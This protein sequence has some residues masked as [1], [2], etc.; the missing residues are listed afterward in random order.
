MDRKRLLIGS[1]MLLALMLAVGQALALEKVRFGTTVKGLP[2][3]DLPPIV[4][5]QQGYWK[6]N[7]LEV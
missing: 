3:Y 2:T 1:V 5:E 7:G 4:A 6:K